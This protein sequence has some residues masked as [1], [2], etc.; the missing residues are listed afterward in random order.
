MY[1]LCVAY[2]SNELSRKVA[3][4]RFNGNAFKAE[5]FAESV[6]DEADKICM[7]VVFLARD[8][9]EFGWGGACLRNAEYLGFVFSFAHHESVLLFHLL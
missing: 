1:Q 8:E 4:G 7:E 3:R 2:G 9:G 5:L 6:C